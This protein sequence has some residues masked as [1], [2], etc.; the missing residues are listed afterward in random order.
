M[1]SSPFLQQGIAMPD[2]RMSA[3]YSAV[4]PG[5]PTLPMSP[6]YVDALQSSYIELTPGAAA[7]FGAT[8]PLGQQWPSGVADAQLAVRVSEIIATTDLMSITKKQV[9][10]NLMA[11]FGLSPDEE[12][13][14]RDFINQCITQELELRQSSQ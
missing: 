6:G 10:Q 9:R 8:S 14:R 1:N 13:A 5:S 12:K 3:A 4:L 11:Q 7:T 2:P